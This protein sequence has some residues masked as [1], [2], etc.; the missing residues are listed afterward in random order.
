LKCAQVSCVFC[1]HVSQSFVFAVAFFHSSVR[2]QYQ[3]F[4]STCFQLIK[5][6][7]KQFSL[8][9]SLLILTSNEATIVSDSSS[10]EG[11]VYSEDE[12]EES[13]GEVNATLATEHVS[14]LD[15][16]YQH[17]G[18]GEDS[19]W[20]M[21]DDVSAGEEGCD[22]DVGHYFEHNVSPSS[23]ASSS[24]TTNNAI[25]DQTK[26]C[27]H[28]AERTWD[29]KPKAAAEQAWEKYHAGQRANL[30]SRIFNAPQQILTK[31]VPPNF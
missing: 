14:V 26:D 20:M 3:H 6:T 16:V 31:I 19:V 15:A 30:R 9:Q 24:I 10:S 11:E 17:G 2:N 27:I 13:F 22:S 1:H 5:S 4:R 12:E 7:Q 18:G 21:D 8:C 29:S 28:C 25:F 23:A